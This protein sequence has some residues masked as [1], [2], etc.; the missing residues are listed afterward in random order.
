MTVS[1]QPYG[2]QPEVTDATMYSSVAISRGDLMRITTR[3]S[4]TYN[5]TTDP[6]GGVPGQTRAYVPGAANAALTGTLWGVALEDSVAGTNVRVR[7]RGR[8]VAL[9]EKTT[10]NVALNSYLVSGRGL[11]GD[12]NALTAAED[13]AAGATVAPSARKICAISEGTETT[14]TAALVPV[15]FN[16]IEGFGTE[17]GDTAA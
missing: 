7:L 8:V 13:I 9:V 1:N 17:V 2:W 4:I 14:G 15:L 3:F 6:T 12:N 10:T 11:T 5:A 16:G